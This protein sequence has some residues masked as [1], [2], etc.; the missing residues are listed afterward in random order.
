MCLSIQQ[1]EETAQHV[2]TQRIPELITPSAVAQ[3]Q[4]GSKGIMGSVLPSTTWLRLGV[5]RQS[6]KQDFCS[7]MEEDLETASYSMEV[8]GC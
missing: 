3:D 7:L 8:K 2:E 5:W 4:N 1:T 6:E